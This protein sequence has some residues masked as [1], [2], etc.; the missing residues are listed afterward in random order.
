MW[1][2]T[3]SCLIGVGVGRWHMSILSEITGFQGLSF[4]KMVITIQYWGFAL[5]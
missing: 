1:T 5:R 3:L 2:S 4:K